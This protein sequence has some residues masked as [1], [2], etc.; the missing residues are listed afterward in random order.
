MEAIY[1]PGYFCF[2]YTDKTL[3]EFLALYHLAAERRGQ[4]E[5]KWLQKVAWNLKFAINNWI[6]ECPYTHFSSSPLLP[7]ALPLFF[8]ATLFHRQLT[9]R[10][11]VEKK[12]IE[13]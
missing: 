11:Y 13:Q 8:V 9:K 12:K 7:V 2:G 1:L 6:G 5:D 10:A 3:L 4:E